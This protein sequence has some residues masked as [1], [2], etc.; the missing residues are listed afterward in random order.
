[1]T[2]PI[3]WTEWQPYFAWLPVTCDVYTEDE[4]AQNRGK[5]T[6]TR[7]GWVERRLERWIDIDDDQTPRQRWQYRRTGGFKC[8][9]GH[10]AK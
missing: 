6:Y 9:G 3:I 1:M 5:F 8:I 4:R 7:I 10:G 2:D